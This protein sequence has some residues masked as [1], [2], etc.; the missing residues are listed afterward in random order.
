MKRLVTAPLFALA[1]FAAGAA[2]AQTEK[3]SQE[4]VTALSAELVSS[5]SGLQTAFQQSNQAQDPVMQETVAQIVDGLGLLEF[6]A[7]HLNAMLKNGAGQTGTL[8]AYRHLQEFHSELMGYSGQVAITAFL[9]P[10]LTKAKTTLTKL[11]AYYP[12]AP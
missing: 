3:W 9:S 7:I 5:V 2:S 6:E 4:K 8:S 11:A 1:L 12:P 10:P